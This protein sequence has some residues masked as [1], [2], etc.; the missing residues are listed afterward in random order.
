MA[1]LKAIQTAAAPTPAGHYAQAI[2][3]GGLVFVAGQLPVKPGQK[4]HAIGMIEDQA[5]QALANLDAILQAAGSSRDRV[6]RV[7]LYVSDLAHWGRVNQVYAEFF[8][9]HR[10]ART[11]VPSGKLH[12][13]YDLELDAIAAAPLAD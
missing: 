10:P 7:T 6:L 3:H 5:R 13:G 1:E 9:A 8:G 4:E 2:V 11:V 12:Y